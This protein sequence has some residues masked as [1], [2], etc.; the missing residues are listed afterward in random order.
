MRDNLGLIKESSEVSA[1]AGQ[2]EKTDGV[3]FV[4]AFSG[5][6]RVASTLYLLSQVEG[7][8]YFV[9]AFSGTQ[10]VA[11]TLFLPSQVHRV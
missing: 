5:T 4:P 2:V 9:P 3:Y 7:C 10:R 6:Q 1:L 11:S 8:V